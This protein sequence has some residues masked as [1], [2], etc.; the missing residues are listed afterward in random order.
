[1]YKNA[2]ILKFKY[3]FHHYIVYKKRHI[4]FSN[5]PLLLNCD[6]NN[7]KNNNTDNNIAEEPACINDNTDVIVVV[8]DTASDATLQ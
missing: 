4:R 3:K 1:M 6:N 5:F 7:N 2:N 8:G